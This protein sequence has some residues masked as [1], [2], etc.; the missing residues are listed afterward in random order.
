MTKMLTIIAFIFG[1]LKF[2]EE[3]PKLLSDLFGGGDLFK[4]FDPRGKLVGD[5]KSGVS[6]GAKLARG[7]GNALASPFRTATGVGKAIAG[8]GRG[9]A[10]GGSQQSGIHKVG[11]ALRGMVAGGRAAYNTK[12]FRG[13]IGNAAFAGAG[14]G[15]ISNA[16]RTAYGSAQGNLNTTFTSL[17]DL[18]KEAID[19]KKDEKKALEAQ[20]K[21]NVNNYV[22]DHIESYTHAAMGDTK[23]A[24]AFRNAFR[25]AKTEGKSVEE[26][27]RAGK[28]AQQKMASMIASERAN[29]EAKGLY[30]A[31]YN[32]AKGKLDLK[33][34]QLQGESLVGNEAT[35]MKAMSEF[36]A[37]HGDW[38]N[39]IQAQFQTNL[40]DKL[41]KIENTEIASTLNKLL[42]DALGAGDYVGKGAT[43][44][45]SAN[46]LNTIMKSMERTIND[47]TKT[48]EEKDAC[49]T[50]VAQL[51]NQMNS[52]AKNTNANISV[53]NTALST[54]GRQQSENNG[55]S[56][57]NS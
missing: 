29:T 41:A 33:I 36:Q 24:D 53:A 37:S 43:H 49:R 17:T 15:A 47:A 30:E 12:G 10:A 40:N 13:T 22:K 26:C 57:G 42:S 35:V 31:A 21:D 46:D 32:D 19:K 8:A 28:E 51:M 4:K 5:I 14:A 48:A 45:V 55:G 1:L 50:A 34:A 27:T 56:G 54:Y 9:L 16:N 39:T 18:K 6:N 52:A 3:A 25:Q 23:A 44:T 38:G 2:A 20:Y 7:A 11:G